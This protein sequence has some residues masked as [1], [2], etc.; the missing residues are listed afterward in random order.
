MGNAT[1]WSSLQHVTGRLLSYEYDVETLISAHHIWGDTDLLR[2]FEVD[3]L[4]SSSSYPTAATRLKPEAVDIIINRTPQATPSQ[5]EALKQHA[6]DLQVYDLDAMLEEQWK[7][8]LD[9]IVH[10]EVLLHDWLSRT[11]G[12]VQPPRF[13]SNW[14]YIGTSKPICRLCQYYFSI[15]ATPV[16]FRDGHPNTYLD[17][18]PADVRLPAGSE[19]VDAAKLVWREV[20]DQM[21]ARVY[22]DMRRLLVEKATDK[23]QNDSNTYTDRIT[24]DGLFTNIGL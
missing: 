1:S 18:R 24:L 13:F 16:R 6:R 23:K 8:K 20:I 9:P 19:D 14:R 2:D 17:W 11:A 12:G 22:A 7:R 5:L 4:D 21:K 10:A 15:I 3:F